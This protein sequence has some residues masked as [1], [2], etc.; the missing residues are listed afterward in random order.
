MLK[1]TTGTTEDMHDIKNA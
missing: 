1:Q